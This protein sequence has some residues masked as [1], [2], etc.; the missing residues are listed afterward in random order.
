MACSKIDRDPED[1]ED[2]EDLRNLTFKESEG[3][4]DAKHT[5]LDDANSSY[6]KPLKL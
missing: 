6:S 1:L 2:L 5:N 3:N 4:R